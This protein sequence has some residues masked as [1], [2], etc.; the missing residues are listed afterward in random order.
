MGS[1]EQG[2]S[3]V[4]AVIASPTT[5]TQRTGEGNV[6]H[7]TPT[8]VLVIEKDPVESAEHTEQARSKRRSFAMSFRAS[9]LS[10]STEN[11][12]QLAGYGTASPA[13]AEKTAQQLAVEEPIE[14]S[15]PEPQ[16]ASDPTTVPEQ[17]VE[18]TAEQSTSAPSTNPAEASTLAPSE[19][20]HAGEQQPELA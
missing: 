19:P 8:P 15:P 4:P 16:Q 13:M 1:T 11:P 5:A 20:T 12:N 10:A 2:G 9:K 7:Q 18:K 14:E 17:L 3:S 6:E